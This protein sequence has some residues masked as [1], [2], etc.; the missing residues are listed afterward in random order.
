MRKE[1][2]SS[3]EA[4][5][6]AYSKIYFDADCTAVFDELN[7]EL[8]AVY[9]E[10]YISKVKIRKTR[11]PSIQYSDDG[12]WICQLLLA[13]QGKVGICEVSSGY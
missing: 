2:V 10:D 3:K 12:Y 1:L 6:A 11:A 7:E 8:T 4:I 5:D 13:K 9:G